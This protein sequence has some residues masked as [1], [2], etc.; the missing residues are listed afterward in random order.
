MLTYA[1]VWQGCGVLMDAR[2]GGE[3]RH[4]EVYDNEL[5]G[6]AIKDEACPELYE[7]TIRHGRDAGAEVC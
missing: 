3:L 4:C 2:S 6:I 5:A 7:C 1:D